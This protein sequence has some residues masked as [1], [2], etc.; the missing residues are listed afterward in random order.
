MGWLES[1]LR[2]RNE[3]DELIRLRHGLEY[4]NATFKEKTADLSK[5]S[6]EYR[7]AVNEGANE[8]YLMSAE[9]AE[10]E[11]AQMLRKAARWR[12]HV[13]LRPTNEDDTEMWEWNVIHG[14]HY[15]S[16]KAMMQI[17]R[18]A[19]QE[20][21]MRSKPWLSWMAILISIISLVVSVLR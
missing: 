11:T 3:R 9:I 16:E 4:N 17:R 18:D 8:H 21:E 13:P 14:R 20:F 15:L 12:I 2:Y 6:Q 7:D 19:Y 1:L 10:I 5:R